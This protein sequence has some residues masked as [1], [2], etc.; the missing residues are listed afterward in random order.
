MSLA[1]LLA[2]IVAWLAIVKITGLLVGDRA[3]PDGDGRVLTTDE[4][5][6]AASPTAASAVR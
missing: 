3:D 2:A 5:S 6:W 4:V 1:G